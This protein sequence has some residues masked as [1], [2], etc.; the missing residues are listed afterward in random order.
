M[1]VATYFHAAVQNGK[2]A[3]GGAKSSTT[4]EVEKGLLTLISSDRPG[5]QVL[6]L[7]DF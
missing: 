7:S 3:I 6:V 5:L 1:L 4:G 2:A